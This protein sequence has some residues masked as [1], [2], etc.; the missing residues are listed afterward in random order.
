MPKQHTFY[1]SVGIVQVL[2]IPFMTD[3]LYLSPQALTKMKV[4]F[5]TD[6]AWKGF[7]YRTDYDASNSSFIIIFDRS[8]YQFFSTVLMNFRGFSPGCGDSVADF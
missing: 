2:C 6:G 5:S 3:I 1:M 7:I 8:D 4:T